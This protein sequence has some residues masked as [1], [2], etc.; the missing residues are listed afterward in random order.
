MPASPLQPIYHYIADQT[1]MENG[2]PLTDI[3]AHHLISTWT[4]SSFYQPDSSSPF[5]RWRKFLVLGEHNSSCCGFLSPH[6]C[7]KAW[8]APFISFVLDVWCPTHSL[9][10]ID[11]MKAVAKF[12]DTSLV[13]KTLIVIYFT[14]L[15]DFTLVFT[16]LSFFGTPPSSPST[17]IP[18]FGPKWFGRQLSG[19][20]RAQN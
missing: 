1:G 17:S 11:A 14:I 5:L 15:L 2:Q 9:S 8:W 19:F 4:D 12:Q 10:D 20:L 13:K 6:T 3:T 16:W 18:N 7:P